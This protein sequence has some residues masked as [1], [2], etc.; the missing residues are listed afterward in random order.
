MSRRRFLAIIM[1]VFMIL[2]LLP[3]T[4]FAETSKAL[5]GQLKIQGLAAAG[6]VLSAD[7]KGIKTEGVTE[8][9]VSYEWFRKTPEDEKKEQ[10]GEKPE[11]KQLG[12]EKT[13]TI[14]KDDVDSKIVLTITGLEDKGFS[15]SLTA[16]TA[17]VAETV[18][19]AE[20]NQTKTELNT[21][22]MGEN[23]SQ[24]ANASEE[25]SEE[26]LE[27]P[28]AKEE[29][30]AGS[31]SVDGIPAATEDTETSQPEQY[32]QNTEEEP[33]LNEYQEE[34]YP[35]ES[36]ESSED[37]ENAADNEQTSGD[38]GS[39]SVEGIPAA[40]EDGTYGEGDSIPEDTDEKAY[41]AEAEVGD[42]SSDVLNFGNVVP[43]Q[44]DE[45][46]QYITIKNT[47]TETLNFVGISPEHFAVQDI[48]EPLE[49]GQSVQVWIA[50][51]V[52]TQSG[53]YDDTITYQTEEGAEASFQAQMTITEEGAENTP[54]QAPENTPTPEPTQIP[55]DTPTPEPTQVPEDTPTPEPTQIP[56][57]T[58][59]P[60]PTQVPLESKVRSDMAE[61]DFGSVVEGYTEA[62]QAKTATLTNEGNADAVL[63]DV[64]SDQGEIRYFDVSLS[65]QQISANGGIA[66]FS[67]RPKNNLSAGTYTESFTITDTTSGQNIVLTASVTVDT[68]KHSLGIS[69]DTLDFASAKKGYNG[70][71]GQQV[72]VTNNGNVTET[73]IQP[74]AKYFT[75][76]A[77][78][79]LTI[80]PGETAVF[81][82]TPTSGLDVNSYQETIKIS[83]EATETAFDA[84]FQVLKGT[85]SLTK[86][87]NPSDISGIANGTAKDAQKLQ[88]PSVVVIETTGGKAKAKVAWDVQNCSYKV[89]DTAAQS[90]TVKGAVTLPDG[91]D[92]DNKVEL[93]AYVKVNVEAYAPK[94]ASADDNKI[95]GIEHNGVYTTQSKI[96]F[97]AVGAG[98]DNS[99]P[100]KG[101][102]RYIP[103]NWTVI[104]TNT[105]D[106]APY[107]AC[108]GLAKS[109]DYTLKVV[110]QQQQY[111][112]E[113]WKNTDAQDT[114]QVAFSI[115]KAKV[116]AP[117]TNVT[118]TANQ[119]K[120]VRTNDATVILP[121]V[122][123]LLIAVGA[124]CGIIYYKKKKK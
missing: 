60:E 97:T 12:K 65:S 71:G 108:F 120:S 9:S 25:T 99:S 122:I 52:G 72:T 4:V 61:A 75:V 32:E 3:A 24:D 90:F 40:T 111:N 56:E 67:V 114:K 1:S 50:P 37:V 93:A 92:N 103:L 20:Q 8:D 74:T 69:T 119:K 118:P 113:S 7:L 49:A 23:E 28:E 89:S 13:Y 96:S 26:T 27:I 42:G 48:T 16:T 91:V 116:T 29:D 73:L 18:E 10:Q 86:I 83:S 104:N 22:D 30:E 44:E 87:Q 15:G 58:P 59:T 36:N 63:S 79:A 94:K 31:E 82:V 68:A 124:I 38:A 43:G 85:V 19:A 107:T 5:D 110:F 51:R 66:A 21:E 95:T 77:S 115:T 81:T 100:K 102:I 105:W 70:I 64:F 39:S 11:L 84:Y 101:D 35:E 46:A 17:T 14:V 53:T 123:V 6:T 112:G 78:S 98:M 34:L 54:T 88:L 47:G 106:E 62:P 121:F 33:S 76:T 41:Q 2:S 55:E 45:L 109:G 117:G 80:Q 57:D